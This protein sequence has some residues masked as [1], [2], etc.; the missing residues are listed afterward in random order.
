MEELLV[1]VYVYLLW[2]IEDA[3]V[4]HDLDKT[5]VWRVAL[6][7]IHGH[8]SYDCRFRARCDGMQG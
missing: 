1:R 6:F 5:K 8:M 4:C 7:V 3:R 2:H